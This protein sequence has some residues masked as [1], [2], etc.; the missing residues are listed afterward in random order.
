MK[1]KVFIFDISRCFG[2]NGCTA[3]C[4]NVNASPDGLFLRSVHKLPPFDMHHN[5][6]YLSV[7]CNHCENAPCVNACP[8]N[9]IYKEAKQGLV[10]HNP[11]ECLGCRFC[12]MA[13][14]YDAIKWNS[15]LKIISKCNLCHHRLENGLEPA[16]VETCF[17]GALSLSLIELP[18]KTDELEKEVEGFIHHKD[19]KPCIRF[20]RK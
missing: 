2:C 10:L 5:T 16:C 18:E 15:D 9:A 14:P 4:A 19:V 11:E 13:C 3:A 12:Q 8:S 7:S 1:Q 20:K 17:S 6:I